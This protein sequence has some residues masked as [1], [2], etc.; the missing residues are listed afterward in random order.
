M[1]NSFRHNIDYNRFAIYDCP[2]EL[3]AIDLLEFLQRKMRLRRLWKIP[4]L[5]LTDN[6]CQGRRTNRI[7]RRH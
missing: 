6:G 3:E 2:E 1:E 5:I 4:R 7:G